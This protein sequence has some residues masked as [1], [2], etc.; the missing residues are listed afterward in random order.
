MR[1][2]CEQPFLSGALALVF[3]NF[4]RWSPAALPVSGMC[5]WRKISV[6]SAM[7]ASGVI[8]FCL[9]VFRMRDDEIDWPIGLDDRARTL[10]ATILL[11][12]P[13]DLP[14]ASA[15]DAYAFIRSQ[16]RGSKMDDR[17]QALIQLVTAGRL[18]PDRFA[19]WLHRPI[20]EKSP[21]DKVARPRGRPPQYVSQNLSRSS[22]FI[23]NRERLI[24][25]EE[26]RIDA[27]QAEIESAHAKIRAARKEIEKEESFM[28]SS[29]FFVMLEALVRAVE[30][31]MQLGP[32]YPLA[33][34]LGER[35]KDDKIAFVL[36]ALRDDEVFRSDLGDAVMAVIDENL[37]MAVS[38]Y[39]RSHPDFD[40]LAPD[41]F[42]NA[43]RAAAPWRA[44][45][46]DKP[47]GG[48]S[49]G[50]GSSR[51]DDVGDDG[52]TIVSV[53]GLTTP[54]FEADDVVRPFDD[55]DHP[56]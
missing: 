37:P 28:R 27:A 1:S 31:P 8:R 6:N 22:D 16:M 14:G 26:M 21:F 5:C 35:D 4:R 47:A 55:F 30:K 25:N 9:E 23:A 46:A 45:A 52:S 19:S 44:S 54:A 24:S 12:D 48:F 43:I 20:D 38:T 3:S 18:D 2:H 33:L 53:A 41:A 32:L 49:A 13:S 15:K 51:A 34:E 40:V 39:R 10:L 17:L 42:A 7:S 50:E 36:T 56:V 11:N 29:T